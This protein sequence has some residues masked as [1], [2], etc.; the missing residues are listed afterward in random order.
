MKNDSNLKLVKP[1]KGGGA[2]CCCSKPSNCQP[3]QTKE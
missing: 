1:L 3:I 2:G